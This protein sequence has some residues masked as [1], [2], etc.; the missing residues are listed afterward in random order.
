MTSKN[1][2]SSLFTTNVRRSKDDIRKKQ[3]Y[4]RTP[5]FQRTKK[6]FMEAKDP[7]S[8]ATSFLSSKAF[9][10]YCQLTLIDS[11]S[12]EDVSFES[13]SN[14]LGQTQTDTTT[15]TTTTETTG[16]TSSDEQNK[17]QKRFLKGLQ[18][19]SISSQQTIIVCFH[20]TRAE[21]IHDI[22]QNGLNP[23]LRQRQA[24]GPGEY[25]SK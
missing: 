24:R 15:T 5:C 17:L 2:A 20:G 21:N 8:D 14:F 18:E 23:Y 12:M 22:L 6:Q 11:Q 7:F 25:F 3:V 10:Q 4:Y 13:R 19:S 1:S 16:T 9:V